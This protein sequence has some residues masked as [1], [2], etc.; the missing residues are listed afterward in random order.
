MV[1]NST[2]FML[3]IFMHAKNMCLS[4]LPRS[5]TFQKTIFNIFVCTCFS[6]VWSLSN[7]FLDISNPVL[8]ANAASTQVDG[9][10]HLFPMRKEWHT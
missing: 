3:P 10:S 7:I 2:F 8:V 6:L 4:S 5:G 1:C 9:S